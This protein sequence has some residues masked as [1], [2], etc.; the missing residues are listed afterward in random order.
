MSQDRDDI[1]VAGD[2]ARITGAAGSDLYFE[3]LSL[4]S[5]FDSYKTQSQQEILDLKDSLDK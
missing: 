4:Q 1:S 3:L 2:E 5:E